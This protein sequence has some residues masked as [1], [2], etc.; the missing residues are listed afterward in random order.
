MPTYEYQCKECEHVEEVR[1]G[2]NEA[3]PTQ[4]PKCTHESLQRLISSTSFHLKGGGWYSDLYGS[5]KKSDSS[6][7]TSPSTDSSSTPAKSSDSAAKPA[8]AKPAKSE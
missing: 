2:M 8:P 1:H 7:E 6:K 3:S 4:C 5:S